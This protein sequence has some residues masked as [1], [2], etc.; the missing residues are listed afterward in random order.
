MLQEL[1]FQLLNS[2]SIV[3]F[4]RKEADGASFLIYQV[5]FVSSQEFF[6]SIKE[7]SKLC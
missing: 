4:S 2:N 6:D 1:N 3:L 7:E 5:S